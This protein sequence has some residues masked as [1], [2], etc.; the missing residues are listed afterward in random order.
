MPKRKIKEMIVTI[1]HL[2]ICMCKFISKYVLNKKYV[3]FIHYYGVTY[4][5]ADKCLDNVD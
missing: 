1:K 3:I 5:R 2:L 4:N